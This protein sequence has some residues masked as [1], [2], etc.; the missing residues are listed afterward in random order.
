LLIAPSAGAAPVRRLSEYSKIRANKAREK[1]EEN[2]FS[3]EFAA[4][5]KTGTGGAAIP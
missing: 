4:L 5:D 1:Y 2:S 3:K